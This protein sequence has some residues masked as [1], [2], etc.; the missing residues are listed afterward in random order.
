MR[1]LTRGPSASH[2]IQAR[3]LV[4]YLT[5]KMPG[6]PNLLYLIDL[7]YLVSAIVCISKCF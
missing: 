6:Y 2:A 1:R 5:R 3:L 7:V 4:R